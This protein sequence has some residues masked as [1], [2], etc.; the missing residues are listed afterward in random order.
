M[1]N[2]IQDLTVQSRLQ[3]ASSLA[4]VI[5]SIFQCLYVVNRIIDAVRNTYDIQ[6]FYHSAIVHSEEFQL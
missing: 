5:T 1:S 4:T 3:L 6:L 2:F